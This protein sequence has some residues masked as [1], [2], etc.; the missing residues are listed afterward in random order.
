MWPMLRFTVMIA[1]LLP[2]QILQ[3]QTSS[4]EGTAIGTHGNA[5]AGAT[6]RITRNFARSG[7]RP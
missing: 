5:L 4:I 3:A 7:G 1:L 6:V 2:V